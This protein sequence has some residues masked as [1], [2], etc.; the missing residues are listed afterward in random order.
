MIQSSSIPKMCPKTISLPSR[1]ST[2]SLATISPDKKK[3]NWDQGKRRKKEKHHKISL[4]IRGERREK[5]VI[6]GGDFENKQTTKLFEQEYNCYIS[7]CFLSSRRQYRSRIIF[8]LRLLVYFPQAAPAPSPK[9]R[10]HEAPYGSG[11]PAMVKSKCESMQLVLF[12]GRK[13]ILLGQYVPLPAPD[14]PRTVRSP[15]SSLSSPWKVVRRAPIIFRNK[16]I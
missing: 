8:R 9:V 11:S 10:K 12:E 14:W 6:K 13:T 1:T 4:P 5:R 16:S 15:L 7:L 3:W 2:G